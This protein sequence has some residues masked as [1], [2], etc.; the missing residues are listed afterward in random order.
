MKTKTISLILLLEG[1]ASSGLQMLTIRQATGYVGSSVLVTSIVVSTF[2]AALALGYYYGGKTPASRYRHI[3]VRNLALS[4]GLF[5]SG[6][7]YPT[8]D[9]FF[10]TLDSATSNLSLVSHPLFHLFVYCWLVLAP[11]VFLLA[12][13]VPL[14]LHTS[15]SDT[16]KSEAAGTLTALSTVGNVVGCLLTA[17]VLMVI[18]GV[19]ASIAINTA[20][21]FAALLI[22]ADIKN[23][24]Q[25]AYLGLGAVALVI[26]FVLNVAIERKIFDATT[27]YANLKVV[28]QVDGRALLVNSQFASFYNDKGEAWPYIE[29]M[30]DALSQRVA[31]NVLVLGAG[32]FTL[33]ATDRVSQHSFTYV[34]IDPKLKD[35]AEQRLLRDA[36]RGVHIAEDARSYLLTRE[37]LF[38]AIVVDL[39]TSSVMI[40]AHT[41]TVEFFDLV[42]AHLDDNG[43]AMINIAA[44]P[45][46]DDDYS[47]RI[48]ATVRAAFDRCVTDLSGYHDGLANIVYFCRGS[49]ELLQESDS[50]V[51]VYRDDRECV[52]IDAFLLANRR[53][54]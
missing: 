33:S 45:M 28:E 49:G 51:D 35:L 44:N 20:I 36:I 5:G 6:L 37:E 46:L 47:R 27:Q 39:F 8:V 31:G 38:D 40:P 22:A 21:L 14:L 41:A 12:Q 9:I 53:D 7:A 10:S 4:I 32:G 23:T 52:S 30:R 24:R 54:K 29:I 26:T 13:T 25:I 18:F 42:E 34:D 16:T 1:L 3:L 50:V 15:G 17:L 2:L 43:V 11:L 48:D 19:G